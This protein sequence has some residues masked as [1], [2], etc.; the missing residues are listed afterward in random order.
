MNLN[1]KKIKIFFIMLL[2]LLGIT[3]CGKDNDEEAYNPIEMTAENSEA[4]E[5]I[6]EP[7]EKPITTEEKNT[8]ADHPEKEEAS[9][10]DAA[11]EIASKG[12]SDEESSEES[13]STEEIRTEETAESVHEGKVIV[14]D[15][16]HS[17]VVSGNTEPLG[18]GSSEM[19]A[20]DS[21][22]THGDSSGLTEC[23]LN[24]A[25]ALKLRDELMSRGYTVILT[26]ED[27]DKQI[28]CSER[29][30]I[31]N[32]ANADVFLRIHADGSENSSAAGAMGICITPSNPYISEMYN[33]SRRLSDDILNEYV[34][35]TGLSSRGIWETDTMTGNNWAIVPT[36][37]LEMG[38]MTNPNEDLLMADPDFQV[39]MIQ[40]IANGIDKFIEEK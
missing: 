21:S 12:D 5:N 31:A 28:S 15:P 37:L 20:A 36:T 25:I 22:G 27:N 34:A 6:S 39:K 2:F 33:E 40:G 19:K 14:L 9:L 7:T 29:A 4:G 32:D 11:N 10:G 35:A 38:F 13:Q 30:I 24:L 23:E 16:G 17:F 8:E 3:S 1:M 26:R 18:P